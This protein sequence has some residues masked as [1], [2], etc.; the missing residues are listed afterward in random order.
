M[1]SRMGEVWDWADEQGKRMKA[2]VTHLAIQ[3]HQL[4]TTMRSIQIPK[5]WYEWWDHPNLVF[6][7]TCTKSEK[8]NI[9]MAFSDERFGRYAR[10]DLH[11]LC[12]HDLTTTPNGRKTTCSKCTYKTYNMETL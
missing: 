2:I 1:L 8:P 12:D 3:L 7:A 9:L 10:L 6:G 4:D 5:S 11:D